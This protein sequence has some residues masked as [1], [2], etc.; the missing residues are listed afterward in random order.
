LFFAS[1]NAVFQFNPVNVF[2]GSANV[3]DEY[4]LYSGAVFHISNLQSPLWPGGSGFG[5]LYSG[6]RIFS[7]TS[8]VYNMPCVAGNVGCPLGSPAPTGLGTGGTASVVDGSGPYS[9][10]VLLTTGTGSSGSGT[11]YLSFPATLLSDTSAVGPCTFITAIGP[12]S[13]IGVW[14]AYS[15]VRGATNG[16]GPPSDLAVVWANGLAG[17]PLSPQNLSDNSN[18]YVNYTCN[19]N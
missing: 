10:Q 19:N 12:A 13:P 9:G 14:D 5:Y 3:L 1:T 17:S 8:T 15:W 7:P 11:L 18:Y 4:Q 6:A 2:S 16:I